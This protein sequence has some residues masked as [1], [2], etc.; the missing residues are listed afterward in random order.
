MRGGKSARI[1]KGQFSV[2]TGLIGIVG[3]AVNR[4]GV[5]RVGVG[6]G[7]DMGDSCVGSGSVDRPGG[8]GAG[9]QVGA[10]ES[11]GGRSAGRGDFQGVAVGW[12][13]KGKIRTVRYGADGQFRAGK[14]QIIGRGTRG[15]RYVAVRYAR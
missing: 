1:G 9:G 4:Y 12:S 11:S 14:R 15:G 10:V 7:N 3:G 13:L 2:G 5:P 6:G 8:N